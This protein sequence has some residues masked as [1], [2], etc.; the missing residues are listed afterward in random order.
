MISRQD[1]QRLLHHADSRA[2]ILTVFLD[3]DVNE[4]NKR[5][6]RIF[7]AQQRTEYVGLAGDRE[8]HP[9]D[10][11]SAAFDRV[12]EWIDEEFDVANKG[13][14][15]YTAI[16]GEWLEGLQF[17]VSVPNRIM[18]GPQ[19]AIGPL[20]QILGRPQHYGVIVVE[21][22]SLRMIDVQF[23]VAQSE[24]KVKTSAYPTPGDVKAGGEASKG[25]QKWKAEESRRFFK[26]FALEVGEFVSR[27]RPAGLILMG[28]TDNVQGFMD[29]LPLDLR[30]LIVHIDNAP[31][32]PTSAEV[33]LRLAPF[34]EEHANQ[35]EAETIDLLRDRVQQ[36][37]FAV[38]GFEKTLE[39]LQEGKLDTLVMARRAERSGTHC[40]R[41]G[42]YLVASDGACRY[43][44]GNIEKGVDLV[45][46]MIRLA[47]EQEVEITFVDPT[48]VTDLDGTGGLLRF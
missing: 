32:V 25:Y 24:Y 12:Q 9:R 36:R 11:I 42:F 35:V 3:M 19:P 21:R 48:A 20:A 43:C 17:P 10:S 30:Q 4:E 18:V 44:G 28:T 46:A 23:G 37:Y 22:E 15:I 14:A 40:L 47:A 13:A 1:I 5:T 8:A 34:F 26:E 39:Q 6:Y 45:E 29:A 33:L 27:Y 7:L 41:C 16:G 38:A 2:P 31:V